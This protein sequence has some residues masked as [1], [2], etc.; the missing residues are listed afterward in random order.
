[1]RPLRTGLLTL[2]LLMPPLVP[3]LMMRLPPPG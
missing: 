2:T 3:L 1:M